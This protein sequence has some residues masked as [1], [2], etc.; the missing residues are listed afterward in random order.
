M[1][2]RFA[3]TINRIQKSMLSELNK[4][5][6][7][8]LFLLGFEDEL[9]NFTLGLSNPSRQA[10][11][12]GLDVW[13]EKLLVYKDAV[14]QI[15][16]IAPVSVTFAKKH[17]LGMSEEEIK[18]DLQQQRLEVAVGAEIVA[19]PSVIP[20]TGI[21]NNIDKLYGSQSGT[22]GTTTPPPTGTEELGGLSPIGGSE[23]GGEAPLETPPP[24]APPTGEAPEI[25]PESIRGNRLN[26]LL[27]SDNQ[28]DDY[29]D[30]TK[31]KNY[32]GNI[33]GTLDKLLNN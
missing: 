18:L 4:V 33:S 10:D 11:L 27:E 21:F 8:H 9:D 20:K 32:L 1:D 25:T 15:Q 12:L 31:G 7:I 3:R 24:A 2:V 17:I 29:I 26:M 6:I 19:S 5:A 22:T 23:L 28:L 16:G 13:K 30:L 14:T